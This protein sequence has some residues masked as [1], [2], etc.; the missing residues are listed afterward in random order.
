MPQFGI[1][2]NPGRNREILFVVQIQ[3][4]RL[5][6]SVGRVVLPLVQ[7][8]SG[9]PPDH[10]LTPHLTVRGRDVYANPL[11]MATI[12]TARLGEVLETLPE[13]MQD[14]IVRA[15]DEMISRA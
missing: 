11:D 9:A 2:R 3:S 8:G 7:R 10:P 12:P 1:Y 6:R 5:D 4:T 14:Q 15:I 13:R